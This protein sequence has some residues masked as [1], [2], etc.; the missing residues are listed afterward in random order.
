MHQVSCCS[1][2]R[3]TR[4]R[5]QWM[6]LRLGM[7]SHNKWGLV[8]V[9][10]VDNRTHSRFCGPMGLG[11]LSKD[12][13]RGLYNVLSSLPRVNDA[14]PQAAGLGLQLRTPQLLQ[15]NLHQQEGLA[16][17]WALPCDPHYKLF[18]DQRIVLLS[19]R[20]PLL[21]LPFLTKTPLHKSSC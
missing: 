7:S 8:H 5:P 21:T 17:R 18:E 3:F 15:G 6:G 12:L 2:S 10:P 9:L 14:R 19:M 13:P 1:T 20:L 4:G 16:H 11:N